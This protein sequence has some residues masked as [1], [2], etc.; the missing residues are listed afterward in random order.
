MPEPAFEPEP[1]P[2][3][4]PELKPEPE[5]GPRDGKTYPVRRMLPNLCIQKKLARAVA[6][7]TPAYALP[8]A[9]GRSPVNSAPTPPRRY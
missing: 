9:T 1:E 5:P 6:L 4:E 8:P 2:K 3:P 7:T